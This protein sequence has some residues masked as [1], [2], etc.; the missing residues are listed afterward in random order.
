[1]VEGLLVSIIVEVLGV[2]SLLFLMR[3]VRFVSL[4]ISFV[5]HVTPE[6]KNY[7]K[8]ISVYVLQKSKAVT[9]AR[10]AWRVVHLQS[11]LLIYLE[12]GLTDDCIGDL[13]FLSG[14][15]CVTVYQTCLGKL[16]KHCDR[17]HE[18]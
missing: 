4:V 2:A 12:L 7:A 6:S 16:Y 1:M 11:R 10:G 15:S 3:S 13:I 14:L 18:E 9:K 17:N 5:W 8:L